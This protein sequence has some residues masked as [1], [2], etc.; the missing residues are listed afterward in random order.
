M[1]V[2]YYE[3]GPQRV[4][5]VIDAVGD[6]T[7]FVGVGISE[8]VTRKNGFATGTRTDRKDEILRVGIRRIRQG[9]IVRSEKIIAANIGGPWADVAGLTGA[10]GSKKRVQ[11]I[12]DGTI[13]AE[14]AVVF[15]RWE[16]ITDAERIEVARYDTVMAQGLVSIVDESDGAA[17]YGFYAV[18]CLSLN[19][20]QY[21]IQLIVDDPY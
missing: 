9:V 16:D 2:Q 19:S 18:E 1:T 5:A 4:V 3:A 10:M 7:P 20:G 15:K 11:L 17:G 14:F 8:D 21:A 6:V 13:D 12:T